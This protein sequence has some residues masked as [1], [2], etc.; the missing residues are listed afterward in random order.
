MWHATR[1]AIPGLH[2][3]S[4]EAFQVRAGWF[5]QEVV[6]FELRYG[7]AQYPTSYLIRVENMIAIGSCSIYINQRVITCAAP[8]QS[9]DNC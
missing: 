4:S 8:F 1:V 7:C 9:C 6:D 3:L 2:S 5:L